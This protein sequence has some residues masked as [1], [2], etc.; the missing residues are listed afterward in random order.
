MDAE[1]AIKLFFIITALFIFIGIIVGVI[2]FILL[3]TGVVCIPDFP[4]FECVSK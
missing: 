3:V 1:D 4:V 2:Y